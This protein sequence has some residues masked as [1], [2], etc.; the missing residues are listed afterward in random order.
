[1]AL[2]VVAATR[3]A[4]ADA[5][6]ASINVG[7]TQSGGK[8]MLETSGDAEVSLHRFNATAFDAG[9]TG[10]TGV[11]QLQGLP[12]DDASALGGTVEH[13][14]IYDRN[15]L[16]QLEG[17]VAVSGKDLDLSSL[18]VGVGDTVSLTAFTI[19]VP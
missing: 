8:L 2:V 4:L 16:K 11:I 17:E 14:S 1:M 19:T 10:G 9:G 12:I 3:N 15:D 7:V 5:I 6:D 13:Y 18:S